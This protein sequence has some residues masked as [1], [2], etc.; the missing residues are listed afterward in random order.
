MATR[1]DGACVVEHGQSSGE[2][3][4]QPGARQGVPAC[5]PSRNP[6]ESEPESHFNPNHPH[7]STS[8]SCPSAL[9]LPLLSPTRCCCV[10]LPNAPRLILLAA[11]RSLSVPERRSLASFRAGAISG[12]PILWIPSILT[13]P[14]SYSLNVLLLRLVRFQVSAI[15]HHDSGTSAEPR[16][17]S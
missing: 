1:I 6:I 16:P 10:T 2:V 5:R 17:Q 14:C 9:R 12:V 7:N 8:T 11:S 15:A 13:L 3:P 4:L